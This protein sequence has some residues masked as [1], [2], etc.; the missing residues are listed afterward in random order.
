MISVYLLLD[1]VRGADAPYYDSCWQLDPVPLHNVTHLLCGSYFSPLSILL[2][3][4]TRKILISFLK[5]SAHLV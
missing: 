1:L 4:Q 3:P 5:K 2:C